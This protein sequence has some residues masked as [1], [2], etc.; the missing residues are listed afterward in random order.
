MNYF[1]DLKKHVE[2]SGRDLEKFKSSLSS[3]SEEEITKLA[4]ALDKDKD[5]FVKTFDYFYQHRSA[6]DWKVSSNTTPQFAQCI[7]DLW[8]SGFAKVDQMFSDEQLGTL[9]Q[10][11]SHIRGNIGEQIKHSGFIDTQLARQGD[12]VVMGDSSFKPVNPNYGNASSGAAEQFTQ[13]SLSFFRTRLHL[14][15]SESG[16][17]AKVLYP[18]DRQ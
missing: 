11:E 3:L 9:L 8:N 4:D 14:T 2:D 12:S 6:A 5:L 13:V 7:S 18:L 10:V 17:R 1:E 15:F 16:T